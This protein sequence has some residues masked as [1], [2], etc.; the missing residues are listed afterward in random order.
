MS[1]FHELLLRALAAP[2]A[3]HDLVLAGS[4]ALW[5]HGLSPRTGDDL[6]FAVA[7]GTPPADV[8]RDVATA[9]GEAGLEAEVAE[10]SERAGRV[11]VAATGRVCEIHLVREALQRPPVTCGELRVV[12]V[13]DAA[14]LV[15]CS[16]HERGLVGDAADVAALAGRFSHRD[17]ERLA[18]SHDDAFST[19]ELLARLEFLDTCLDAA[20]DEAFEAHGLDERTVAAIRDL[21]RAWVEDIKLRRVE[22]GDAD[23][24]D[25]DVPEVD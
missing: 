19:A 8:A 15:T 12:G 5:A 10:V 2:R 16:F 11:S 14:G 23:Y 18:R 17:L 20:P 7:A 21:A 3:R 9:L 22:D 24:D 25:P 1:P 13:E 4:H 6:T